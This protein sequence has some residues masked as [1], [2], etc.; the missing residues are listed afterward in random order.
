[1]MNPW[2]IYV[3]FMMNDDDQSYDE[4]HNDEYNQRSELN[5]FGNT[6]RSDYFYTTLFGTDNR[7]FNAS[8]ES[9]H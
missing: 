6:H 5:V 9:A 7:Q 4:S 2:Q 8:F 1:M 3:G